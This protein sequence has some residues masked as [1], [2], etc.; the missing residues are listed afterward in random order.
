MFQLFSIVFSTLIPENTVDSDLT[1]SF[2]GNHNGLAAQSPSKISFNNRISWRLSLRTCLLTRTTW[3]QPS[4]NWP[5]S[6]ALYLE[7]FPWAKGF[8]RSNQ[9]WIPRYYIYIHRIWKKRVCHVLH[10]AGVEAQWSCLYHWF[11]VVETFDPWGK[12][13]VFFSSADW[14]PQ[15]ACQTPRCNTQNIWAGD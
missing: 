6:G 5:S 8:L 4:I 7:M 2:P 12:Q 13:S 3:R 15:G 14:E 11:C 10:R 9:K 1:T